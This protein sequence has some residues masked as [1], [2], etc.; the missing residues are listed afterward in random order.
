MCKYCTILNKGLEHPQILVLLWGGGGGCL[1]TSSLW[2]PRDDCSYISP[3]KWACL[4]VF[5][6]SDD[7][8][9]I[10]PGAQSPT[11]D[12]ILIPFF[13][14]LILGLFGNSVDLTF[15]I[16]LE[17]SHLLPLL[18]LPSW[19]KFPSCLL[20]NIAVTSELIIP[21]SLWSIFNTAAGV[22]LL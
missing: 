7:G 14:Y 1:R 10:L 20:Y 5:S 19:S 15:K 3:C 8:S 21:S 17:F 2:I 16:Y 9:S 6:I 22:V 4:T 13:F 12:F 11:L 18:L